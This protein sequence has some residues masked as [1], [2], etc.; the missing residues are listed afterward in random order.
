MIRRG[1][2]ALFKIRITSISAIIF[3]P[4]IILCFPVLCFADLME[5]L[6]IAPKA[7]SLANTCTADPPG[8]M[9]IH[10]NPAGLSKLEEGKM[11]EQGFTLPILQ[12]TT[13]FHTDPDWPGI[14]GQWGPQEGQIHDPVADTEDTNS[15]GV[16]Y[17]PIYDNK[18]NFM[19]G[20]TAGLSSKEP[21]SKWTYALAN[22]APFA[23]GVNHYED[24][25]ASY[26]AQMLYLQHMIYASPGAS[27][28]ISPKLSV[29][30]SVGMGQTA[31][32]AKLHMRSPNEMLALT[33]VLGD[34]TKDLEI[35]ILSELTLPPPWFG[36][37]IGPYDQ[38]ATFDFHARD[39]F[40]PN[41][42][43]GLLYDVNE[44][45]TYGLVYQ[46]AIQYQ[47][48]GGYT[49]EYGGQW[50]KMV[51]WLGS[52][53]LLIITSGIFQLPTN[54]VPYQSGNLQSDS[55]FPQR[56]QT[57]FKIRPTKRLSWLFDANWVDWSV[58][59]NNNFRFDEQIQLLKFLKMIGYTGGDYNMI[60]KRDLKD[61]IAWSTGL[62][63]EVN[64]KLTLRCG[65]E[66]RPT[67]VQD[68]L[69]DT[70]LFFPDLHFIG[71]GA[72]LKLPHDTIVD[73]ALGWIF[74]PSYKVPDN[75]ST[76]M[77]STSFV[78]YGYCP[79]TG[80]NYEQETNIYLISFGLRM[81]FY[82]FVEQQ[83]HLMHKQQ[84]AIHHL[85][86]ILKKPFSGGQDT[87]Q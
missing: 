11:F 28:Q 62:E 27:Y 20:P 54:P 59:E 74:N 8:L 43:L 16:M 70:M 73:I 29:G 51:N 67:S 63:Y 61:T 79:Y 25:P 85:I 65:Y 15:S 23:G 49:F 32:G 50:Q 2:F 33:K 13:K 41:Y 6:A 53:P 3:L 31:M 37:G 18:V 39:D 71:A 4:I 45:F 47:L 36:G 44:W 80:L 69:Y 12:I 38:I 10:Y 55:E 78:Y 46:S 60:V 1:E 26:G 68:H 17:L 7:I 24:S 52:S 14:F 72:G 58:M 82:Q 40:S 81:P 83:K 66:W 86:S 19:L 84:E 57:G 64:Q 75:S 87:A 34:A 76:N 48:N 35:P 56:I 42:N 21:D 5:Q 22:Y 30:M 9:S 77:N